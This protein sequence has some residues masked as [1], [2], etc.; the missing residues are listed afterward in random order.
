MLLI[1]PLD[2]QNKEFKRSLRGYD[3]QEVDIFL[4]EIIDDYEK[5][6]KENIE[7]KDKVGLLSDQI[8]QYNTMEET[9]KN[10][11]IAAQ[12]TADE[13]TSSARLKAANI[14]E[15]AEISGDKLIELANEDVR[16]INKEFEYLKKELFAFKTKYQAFIQ[17]QL[18]SLDQFY[19]EIEKDTSKE[20][21]KEYSKSIEEDSEDT[22]EADKDL[23][24]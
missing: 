17:A 18:I 7:L 21:K 10:T 16:K 14:I 13:M 22:N 15:N 11:L 8:R 12:T 4:D 19:E 9:L 3:V 23:E 24:A 2:I 6:F 5:I 20:E 1:T